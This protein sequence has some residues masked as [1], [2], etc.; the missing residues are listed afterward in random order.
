MAATGQVAVDGMVAVPDRITT[1]PAYRR[2]GLG[3]AMMHALVDEAR[4]VGAT[5]GHLVASVERERLY[6]R[7]GW[8]PAGRVVIGRTVDRARGG[9]S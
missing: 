9:R 7:L 1:V 5:V 8:S 4:T 2:R 6:R 3:G